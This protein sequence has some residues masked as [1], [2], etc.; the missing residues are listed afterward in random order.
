M[1]NDAARLEL[2]GSP[3]NEVNANAALRESTSVP[4][5]PRYNA[6]TE[7]PSRAGNSG[8]SLRLAS[9]AARD[10]L[11]H[12]AGQWAD[13]SAKFLYDQTPCP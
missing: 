2:F 6:G 13:E 9:G 4:F 5:G 1:R 10:R 7:E 11:G 8:C 3:T 12:L